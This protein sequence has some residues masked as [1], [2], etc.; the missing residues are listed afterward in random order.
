MNK[1]KI[2]QMYKILSHTQPTFEETD[3][4]WIT[5]GL[6]STPFKLLVSVAISTPQEL[7]ELEDEELATKKEKR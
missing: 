5:H 7:I 2:V 4:D 3:N 1:T 6:N